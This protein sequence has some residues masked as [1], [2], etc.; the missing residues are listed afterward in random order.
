MYRTGAVAAVMAP[1]E[2]QLLVCWTSRMHTG[3]CF[4]SERLGPHPSWR[5][6]NNATD[7]E[8]P[9]S[10]RQSAVHL[11]N[12]LFSWTTASEFIAKA[13]HRKSIYLLAIKTAEHRKANNWKEVPKV[14]F[15]RLQYHDIVCHLTSA[16]PPW[17]LEF[18]K[19]ETIQLKNW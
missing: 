1:V 15:F 16:A 13:P 7:T 8:H 18:C 11:L 3:V 2:Q 19:I 5:C 4:P 6:V 17:P 10:R 9:H 14:I 12:S